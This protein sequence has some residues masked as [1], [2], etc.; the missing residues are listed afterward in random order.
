MSPSKN[1]AALA[2]L[3]PVTPEPSPVTTTPGGASEADTLRAAIEALRAENELLKLKAT[4]QSHQGLSIRVSQSGAVSIY[5]L[6]RFPVTLY[7]EQ[8]LRLLDIAPELKAFI[9][10]NESKLT[11]KEQSK[12]RKAALDATTLPAVG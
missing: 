4:A 1:T 11:T 6:G 3:A 8:W 2:V 5:G 12:A 10:A 9:T 7:K